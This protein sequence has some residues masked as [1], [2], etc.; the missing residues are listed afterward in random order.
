MR[1]NEGEMFEQLLSIK[2]R[3]LCKSR[4]SLAKHRRLNNFDVVVSKGEI[5]RVGEAV[6]I[7]T[8]ADASC[9]HCC[10]QD[11]LLHAKFMIPI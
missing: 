9:L 1:L 5:I 11:S 3:C 10:M 4:P 8:N 7:L 2:A 6:Y